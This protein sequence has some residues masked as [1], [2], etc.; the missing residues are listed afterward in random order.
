[1]EVEAMTIAGKIDGDDDLDV[2]A[3]DGACGVIEMR[4]WS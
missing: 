1:M 2:T 3:E 4:S